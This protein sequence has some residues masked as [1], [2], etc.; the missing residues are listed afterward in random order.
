MIRNILSQF[1]SKEILENR[2]VEREKVDSDSRGEK[3]S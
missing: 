1:V 2:V 3:Y